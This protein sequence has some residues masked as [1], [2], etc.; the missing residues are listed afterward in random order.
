MVDSVFYMNITDNT[1]YDLVQVVNPYLA[2]LDVS[3]FLAGNSDHF[4]GAGYLVWPG[5]MDS[6]FDVVAIDGNRYIYT[7]PPPLST[8]AGLIPP[9]QSF[10]VQ[11]NTASASRAWARMS[12]RWTTTSGGSH[13]YLLLRAAPSDNGVLR[14]RLSQGQKTGYA[15][16]YYSPKAS[17]EYVRREDIG[18]LLYDELPLTLYSLTALQEPL[19]INASGDFGQR[20]VPLG[21]RIREAGETKLEFTGL[22]TFGHDVYLIDRARGGLETDLQETPE[23]TFTVTRPPGAAAVEIN[24]RFALRTVYT[25][26]GL[27]GVTEAN[28]PEVLFSS[29]DGYL[30]VRSPQA[31]IARLQVYSLSGML[32]YSDGTV[33]REYR[34]AVGGPQTC[35]VRAL[36]E[37]GTL[38]TRKVVVRV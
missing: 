8:P 15:A 21:M 14:I 17:P 13:P 12:P 25:G 33:S 36:L 4:S 30:Y 38:V 6:G 9:L 27:V 1:G 3:K 26:R 7:S 2:W 37:D 19:S 23:Y 18:T 5:R 10:F 11:K 32:L 29:R 34:I 35:I 16:L 20:T 22:E 28:R 31:G 24:D